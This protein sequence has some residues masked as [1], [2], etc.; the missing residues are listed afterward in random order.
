MTFITFRDNYYIWGLNSTT[1]NW[2][3]LVGCL[4]LVVVLVLE[5]LYILLSH[6]KGTVWNSR[7]LLMNKIKVEGLQYKYNTILLFILPGGFSELIYNMYK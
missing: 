4:V 1:E 5:S 7:Q 6:S 2:E 3:N